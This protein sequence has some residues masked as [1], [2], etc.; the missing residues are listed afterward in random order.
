M[1]GDMVAAEDTRPD[2]IALLRGVS[3]ADDVSLADSGRD[4]R[5]DVLAGDVIFCGVDFGELSGEID[6]GGAFVTAA[7]VSTVK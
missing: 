7:A 4:V 3:G 6:L 1:R 5:G 2:T